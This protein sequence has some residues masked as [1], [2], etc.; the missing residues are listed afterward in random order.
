M[1]GTITYLAP[2]D[3]AS[4]KIF[5]KKQKF[6]AVTRNWGHR[7]RG[8]SASGQRN[9]KDHPYTSAETATKTA[10]AAVSAAV[11]ARMADAAQQA[12]DQAAFRAQTQYDTLYRYVWN[13]EWA[14]YKA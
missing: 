4:G 3:N 12:A 7:R 6:T 1:A 11:R 8:C 13:Q 5:G 10:F 9:L 14:A 2:V